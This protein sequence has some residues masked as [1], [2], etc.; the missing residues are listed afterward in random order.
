MIA[1]H[2]RSQSCRA[3]FFG[4]GEGLKSPLS[5]SPETTTGATAALLGPDEGDSS[6]V[7]SPDAEVVGATR[8]QAAI[9]AIDGRVSPKVPTSTGPI[10]NDLRD[11]DLRL[12]FISPPKVGRGNCPAA[13]P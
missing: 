7:G 4:P 12:R 9:G 5:G 8:P 13:P 10:R 1:R 3:A 6:I 11:A 2:T